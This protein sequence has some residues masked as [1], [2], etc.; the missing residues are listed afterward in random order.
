LYL[1]VVG[2]AEKPSRGMPGGAMP[3]GPKNL[4]INQY[5]FYYTKNKSWH[6]RNW[7]AT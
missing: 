1:T 5:S 6:S 7:R 2:G 4:L 3:S